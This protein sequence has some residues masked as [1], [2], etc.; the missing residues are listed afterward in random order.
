MTGLAALSGLIMALAGAAVLY[1][2]ELGAQGRLKR[3]Y[4]AGL[5]TPSTLKSDEA[6]RAA[7]IAAA[8]GLRWAGRAALLGGIVG[9]AVA[10]MDN[11]AVFATVLCL[12]AGGLLAGVAVSTVAG[13]KAARSV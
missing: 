5:R 8:P 12:G 3:N 2:A 11:P 9:I 6:W 13:L 10:F 1:V 7:H 4:W